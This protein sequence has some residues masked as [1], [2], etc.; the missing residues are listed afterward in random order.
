[1]SAYFAANGIR[2][3]GINLLVPWYGAPVCDVTIA[4]AVTL[5]NPVTLAAA[6]LTLTMALAVDANGAA[7]RR[8]R[9]MAAHREPD[10]ARART[11]GHQAQRRAP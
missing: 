1:M 11:H 6:N 7:R 2:V 4:D 9:R 8:L 10:A 5:T 3:T